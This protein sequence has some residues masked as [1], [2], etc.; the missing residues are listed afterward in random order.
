MN[1][2]RASVNM[3]DLLKRKS[4][5]AVE[6]FQRAMKV[7]FDHHLKPP[8]I[9]NVFGMAEVAS[10]FHHLQD[11]D[12]VSK[13]AI[14]LNQGMKLMGGPHTRDNPFSMLTLFSRSSQK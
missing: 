8:R 6:T 4:T 10:A 11:R 3:V 1:V 9:F 12:C 14:E 2:S 5:F 13:L 7:V